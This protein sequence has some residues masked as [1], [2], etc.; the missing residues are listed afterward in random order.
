LTAV[1]FIDKMHPLAVYVA[2]WILVPASSKLAVNIHLSLLER[3]RNRQLTDTKRLLPAQYWL[4][5]GAVVDEDAVHWNSSVSIR[6]CKDRRKDEVNPEGSDIGTFVT[7][8]FVNNHVGR[9]LLDKPE[10][11]VDL[12]SVRGYVLVTCILMYLLFYDV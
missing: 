9:C 10:N 12:S 7:L 8:D 3:K 1:D 2:D 5:I 11:W 6:S 4:R